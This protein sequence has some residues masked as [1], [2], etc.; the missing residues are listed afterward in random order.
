[1]VMEHPE[2]RDDL[3]QLLKGQSIYK[4]I[5]EAMTYRDMK[6]YDESIW[7]L[8]YYTGY[9]KSLSKRQVGDNW[10]HEIKLV[11]KEIHSIFPQYLRML[12]YNT[13]KSQDLSAL[14]KLF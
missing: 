14:Q 5:H 6:S 2:C 12:F 4:P 13:V 10:I 9:V 8:L 1:M 11:N 3:E 7:T